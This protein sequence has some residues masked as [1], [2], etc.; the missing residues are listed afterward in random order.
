MVENRNPETPLTESTSVTKTSDG[1]NVAFVAAILLFAIVT[2]ICAAITTVPRTVVVVLVLVLGGAHVLIEY[3][4]E[5]RTR[6]RI[7]KLQGEFDQTLK[8]AKQLNRSLESQREAERDLLARELFHGLGQ[9]LTALRFAFEHLWQRYERNP[10]LARE[11]L[12]TLRTVLGRSGATLEILVNNLRPRIVS[13]QGLLSALKWLCDRVERG[14][15]LACPLVV[16]GDTH[17]IVPEVQAAVFRIVQEALNNVV[18]HAKAKKASVN[19]R[20]DDYGLFVEIRDDGCGI[21][22]DVRSTA[23]KGIT[24]MLLRAQLLD[25]ELSIKTPVDG[26]TIV[27]FSL[28]KE[29]VFAK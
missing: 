11:N 3:G 16:E 24:N 27:R 12:V 7:E 26:G 4:R 17:K 6:K 1:Q 15:D 9:E 28:R 20:I 29:D 5:Q 14:F 25:G 18:R 21:S 13:E 8:D 23:R 10:E 19:V 2:A 22:P